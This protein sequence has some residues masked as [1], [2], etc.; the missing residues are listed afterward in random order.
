ML[1]SNAKK[2]GLIAILFLFVVDFYVVFLLVNKYHHDVQVTTDVSGQQ[3]SFQIEPKKT[4]VKSK[5][6]KTTNLL[7]ISA[8]DAGTNQSV[9]VNSQF[10]VYL[11][12]VIK[13]EISLKV[14]LIQGMRPT[15]LTSTVFFSVRYS[16]PQFLNCLILR[17][18]GMAQNSR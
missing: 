5:K 11:K 16:G 7:A 3:E 8:V 12:P 14:L 9:H 18:S 13:E 2:P 17:Y 4:V 10:V 6:Q 15:S 1:L